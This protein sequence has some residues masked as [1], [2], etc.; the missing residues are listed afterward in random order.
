MAKTTTKPPVPKG[1]EP[2]HTSYR[3]TA[4]T[5]YDKP[6]KLPKPPKKLNKLSRPKEYVQPVKIV[7]DVTK[8]GVK[9]TR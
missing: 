8:R 5:Y 3:L 4:E 7:A 6:Y 2:V 1:Y 9:R